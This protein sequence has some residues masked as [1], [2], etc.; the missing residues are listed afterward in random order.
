VVPDQ[1]HRARLAGELDAR[2][3]VGAVADQV[4]EAPDLLEPGALDVV[5]DR[6]ERGQVGVDVR[7]Q[8]DSPGTGAPAF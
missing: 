2:V 4:A 3:G 6:A 7:E 1:A 5:E 8:R